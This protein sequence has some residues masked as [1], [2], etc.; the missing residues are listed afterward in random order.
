V[1]REHQ[2]EVDEQDEGEHGADGVQDV[3]DVT[4][5]VLAG[6]RPPG[7]EPADQGDAGRPDDRAGEGPG[8]G[9]GDDQP[10]ERATDPPDRVGEEEGGHGGEPVLSL[11]D[12]VTG[13]GEGDTG[14]RQ[15]DEDAGSR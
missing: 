15:R 13:A 10:D 9:T 11:E 12:P 3:P 6:P 1:T 4:P 7:D 8:G 5:A 2:V 14:E